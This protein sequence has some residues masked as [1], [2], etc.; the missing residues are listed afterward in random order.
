MIFKNYNIS[1]FSIKLIN[2]E[3][4]R[5]KIK[6]PISQLKQRKIKKKEQ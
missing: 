6:R 2:K 5:T 4:N 1:Y 3:R